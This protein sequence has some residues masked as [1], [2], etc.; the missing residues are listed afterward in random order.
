MQNLSYE[1]LFDLHLNGLVSKTDL[2]MK[3]FAL[4][5]IL[6]QWQRG[7]E[8]GLL[9]TTYQTD[10]TILGDAHNYHDSDHVQG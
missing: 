4:G 8:D 1:N 9:Q 5:L 10:I 6:K 7:L 3:G 2:H